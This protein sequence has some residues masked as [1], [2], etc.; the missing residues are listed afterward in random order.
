M[1]EARTEGVF[2]ASSKMSRLACTDTMV[3][4]TYT[5]N[6]ERRVD[7][8]FSVCAGCQD[9]SV[10]FKKKNPPVAELPVATGHNSKLSS[11]LPS[12]FK[13]PEMEISVQA[14]ALTLAGKMWG[15]ADAPHKVMSLHGWL[16]CASSFDFVAPDLA[17]ALDATVRPTIV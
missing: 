3:T 10:F 13:S 6:R 16:D 14:G 9:V 15:R 4:N 17:L 2:E 5:N 8:L 1:L 7:M 12:H 11:T